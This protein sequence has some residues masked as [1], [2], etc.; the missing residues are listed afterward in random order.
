[1]PKRTR[2]YMTRC[3]HAAGVDFLIRSPDRRVICSI[4]GMSLHDDGSGIAEAKATARL[5]VAA[6]NAYTQGGRP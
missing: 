6:L 5:I 4:M 1:M 3:G 2:Y